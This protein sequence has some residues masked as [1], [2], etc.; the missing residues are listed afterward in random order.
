[1]DL[2]KSKN[3]NQGYYYYM[4][5][6]TSDNKMKYK[7]SVSDPPQSK[8]EKEMYRIKHNGYPSG[9]YG[10]PDEIYVNECY[11]LLQ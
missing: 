9:G 5:N 4:A 8:H 7:P 2:G 3:K 11:D 6:D 10:L 1:M